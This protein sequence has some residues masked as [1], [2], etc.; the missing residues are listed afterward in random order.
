MG[1]TG[2]D[3]FQGKTIRNCEAV[4]TAPMDRSGNGAVGKKRR[5]L[6][7]VIDK[8]YHWNNL[9]VASRK[10]VDNKGSAGVDGMS[11]EEWKEKEEEHLRELRRRLMNDTYRSKLDRWIRKRLRGYI[12][13][14]WLVFK[15]PMENKPTAEEFERMGLFLLRKV[16]RPKSHQLSLFPAPL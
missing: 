4:P 14:R 3:T 8:V 9:K 12:Y 7:S 1:A 5:I 16:L 11:V 10:V 15:W 2:G 13:K 6:H